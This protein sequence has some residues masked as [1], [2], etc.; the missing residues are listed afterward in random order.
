MGQKSVVLLGQ[1]SALCSSAGE[2]EEATNVKKAFHS[3][4]PNTRA[5]KH[6]EKSSEICKVC[7]ATYQHSLYVTGTYV[8]FGKVRCVNRASAH[9]FLMHLT[10]ASVSHGA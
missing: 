7:V 5:V 2:G 3:I 6:S 9:M 1:V 4:E 8:Q 10:I